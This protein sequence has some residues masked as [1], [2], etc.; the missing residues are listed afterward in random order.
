M[1]TKNVISLSSVAILLLATVGLLWVS[2][3]ANAVDTKADSKQVSE[4]LSE[5]R[6]QA[7][8]LKVDADTME[9]FT[10]ENV[11]WESHAAKITE[12]KNDVNAVSKTVAK[13][14]NS[15]NTAS[16]WQKVAIDRINPILRETAA[17]VQATL[18]HIDKEQGRFLNTQEH[19]DY[20]KANAELAD[21]MARV[22]SDFVDY[23]ATKAKFERLSQEL[24]VAER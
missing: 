19:K 1:S 14:N 5:A 9:A 4:L 3:V 22:V 7:Y 6:T 15:R 10:R 20:L 13:L 23:G 21:R 18:N 24:E 2:T 17:N 16:A 8:K 12:I 11:S